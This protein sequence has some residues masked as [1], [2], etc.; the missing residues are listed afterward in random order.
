MSRKLT[1]ALA[2]AIAFN[3]SAP[4]VAQGYSEGFKFLEAV[5]KR[6]G[7]SAESSLAGGGSRLVNTK[8][9][10]SGETGLHIVTRDRDL[11][12]LRCLLSKGAKADVENKRG[13]TPLT[14]ATQLGW[15]D[16]AAVLLRAGAKVDGANS[17]GETPLILAVHKRDV[18]M[19]RLLL[20]NGANPQRNDIIAGYSA[21]DYAKRD[22]RSGTIVKLLEEPQPAKAVVA[23]PAR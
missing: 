9:L 11:L 17:R 6:D 16:G 14:L 2:A 5:R 18:P 13:E 19:I 22:D 23:G 1:L 4:V 3:L 15:V 20:A 10:T 12:W 21:L 8:D 7:G